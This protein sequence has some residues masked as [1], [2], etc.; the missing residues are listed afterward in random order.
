MMLM[1]YRSQIQKHGRIPLL[2]A[3][4]LMACTQSPQ[5]AN[6][7]AGGVSYPWSDRL[8]TAAVGN[9]PY[10]DGKT[11]PWV[12]VIGSSSLGRLAS[13][14]NFLSNLDWTSAT[15]AWGPVEKDRSNGEQNAGDGK[16]LT[17]GGQ[18][19][20]KGLGVHAGSEIQ[21]TLGG[22][23]SVFSAQVGLDD[24][25][26][27]LG[28][29]NFQLWNGGTKLYD[30]GVLHGTDSARAVS[31][32]VSG[33]Q[34]LR[35]MVTNG[36]DNID[37]DHADWGDAKVSCESTAPSRGETQLSDLG[38]QSASSAWGP[39]EKD[40]SNGEQGAGDGRALTIGGQVYSKGLGVYAASEISFSLGAN[41]SV[42]SA[43]VGLDD[44]VR[45][46]GTVVFQLWSGGAG[47]AGT[48]K[49]YD[50]GVVRGTD[51]AKAVTVDVTG[52]Q[53]L[54]LVVTDGGDNNYYDH[55]DWADAKVSCSLP[56]GALGWTE[57]APALQAVFEAQGAAVG[58]ALYVFGGFDSSLQTTAASQM[59]DLAA[60][61]WSSV[62]DMPEQ[63]THG[64]VAVDGTIIYIAGGFV[65]PHPGPQTNHVWKYDT[66]ARTWSLGPS[67][68]E[69]RGG[70]A[71][72]RQ[73]RE[74]HF[75]GGT[76]R[77]LINRSVYLRDRPEHW[78]LRLDGGA[79][80][81]NAAPMPNPRN[82]MAGVA[83]G[84]LIYAIGGQH[85]GDEIA[86]NQ[87]DV[88]AYDPTTNSWTARADMPRP[89]GHISSSTFVQNNRIMVIGGVT[90]GSLKA[91]NVIEY[92][93]SS[94]RWAEL[95]PIPEAR[96]SPVAD[97]IGNQVV[98]T[99]G[100]LPSGA[101]TTTWVG[102]RN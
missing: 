94:N 81:T 99:A 8:D 29:V 79:A 12:G 24:E 53:V 63:V 22:F 10:A 49:L 92:D 50:S 61:R 80:W 26:G 77:D 93:P 36:G 40:K 102:S 59:Y 41:C 17:I 89:A 33:V 83:L 2:L 30:S 5:P 15:S 19:Y 65:G 72:V 96:Q 91:A 3:L 54:R 78:V 37:D 95:T 9:N 27:N 25:V 7:Y 87:S 85:L 34:T 97:A 51:S 69:A 82:H 101:F 28:S 62:S 56:S 73:G 35:L 39:V 44:E 14:N 21:Y 42:F 64:A 71:L 60:N 16:P 98:V 55:A 11:H 18:I 6:P 43:Q 90:Q 70:G 75:F 66:V 31:V 47:T 4:V 1:K 57:Q 13:T 67:L 32:N 52:V 68:P 100:A 48:I 45:N 58:G 74:L 46:N 86:G 84:G 20:Q 88:Q 23:C 38:W 76:E